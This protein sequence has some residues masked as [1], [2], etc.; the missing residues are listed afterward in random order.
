MSAWEQLAEA[1]IRT[2]LDQPAAAREAG[3]I[4][5]DPVLPLEVQLVQDITQLDVMAAKAT[6]PAQASLLQRKASELLLRLM[7]ILEREGRPLAAQH[8]AAE[9]S[10]RRAATRSSSVTSSEG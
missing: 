1:R 5:L 7:V 10:A 2:W 9:R 6:D 8:F 4:S 3:G